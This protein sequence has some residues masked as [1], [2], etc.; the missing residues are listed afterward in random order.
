MKTRNQTSNDPAVRLK[1]L[2]DEEKYEE[3]KLGFYKSAYK[4]L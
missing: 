3:V 2:K 1:S 4:A